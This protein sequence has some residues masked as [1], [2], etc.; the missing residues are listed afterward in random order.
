MAVVG[1]LVGLMAMAAPG[2][3]TPLAD[4]AGAWPS[5]SL[6]APLERPGTRDLTYPAWFE[7]TWQVRSDGLTY[8]VRFIRTEAG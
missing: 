4:R 5:W 7:G 1:L 2:W 8:P 6:P 3:A